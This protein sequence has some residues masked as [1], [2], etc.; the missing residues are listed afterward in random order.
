VASTFVTAYK[1]PIKVPGLIV[2][3]DDDPYCT[4][5]AS[6]EIA[7]H[8]ERSAVNA[9]ALGHINAESGVG[10]WV[11]EQTMLSVFLAMATPLGSTVDADEWVTDVFRKRAVDG[12]AG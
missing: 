12:S 4:P 8:W 7:L 5:K 6:K 10:E 3:S 9:G 2:C 1:R 11:Q